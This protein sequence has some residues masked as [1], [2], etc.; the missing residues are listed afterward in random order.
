MT[1]AAPGARIHYFCDELVVTGLQCELA[2]ASGRYANFEGFSV[3]KD[4]ENVWRELDDVGID[5]FA[6]QRDLPAV[7]VALELDG[8]R[9]A[10]HAD[11][12]FH[13]VR[14]SWSRRPSIFQ[15]EDLPVARTSDHAA[16]CF[17]V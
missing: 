12:K 11:V 2:V 5:G 15:R 13:G 14:S 3:Q 6:I 10:R 7:G 8:A 16:D 4:G 1:P 9:L 17:S